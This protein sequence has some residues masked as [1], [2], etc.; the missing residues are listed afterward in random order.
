MRVTAV[1]LPSCCY[2]FQGRASSWCHPQSLLSKMQ[3]PATQRAENKCEHAHRNGNRSSH[4]GAQST[5][6]RRA[7]PF[8]WKGW[9]WGGGVRDLHAGHHPPLALRPAI[10]Y[11][12]DEVPIPPPTAYAPGAGALS[13]L[14][15]FV[16]PA[17]VKAGA[18]RS[19]VGFTLSG[20]YAPG[21]GVSCCWAHI[22]HYGPRRG[23]E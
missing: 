19:R 8:F 7:L 17:I 2:M 21:A 1:C 14:R 23:E 15:S 11:R 5:Y 3:L 16:R 9:R 13:L 22:A 18:V 4:L 20:A 6:P 12:G 10:V